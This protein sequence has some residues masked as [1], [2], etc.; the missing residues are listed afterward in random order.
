MDAREAGAGLERDACVRLG[1]GEV[2]DS[3]MKKG[4]V[5]REPEHVRER[6]EPSGVR[7]GVVKSRQRLGEVF[8]DRERDAGVVEEGGAV[9]RLGQQ[10]RR[11]LERAARKP[12]DRLRRLVSVGS[13]DR[14]HPEHARRHVG[15]FLGQPAQLGDPWGGLIRGLSV[16]LRCTE[17]RGLERERRASVGAGEAVARPVEHLQCLPVCDPRC[18]GCGPARV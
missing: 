5:A 12:R 6:A 8:G 16:E 17:R 1:V 4:A 11:C 7:Y 15:L 9:D 14:Q 18:G 10:L 13:R 3:E 2:A